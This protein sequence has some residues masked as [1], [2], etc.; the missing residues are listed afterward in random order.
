[1]PP[2][3]PKEPPPKDDFA[4]ASSDEED[5]APL[6]LPDLPKF[7]HDRRRDEVEVEEW[8][9]L[10]R[11]SILMRKMSVNSR[12]AM[13]FA[14]LSLR[15]AAATWFMNAEESIRPQ[16]FVAFADALEKWVRPV[17]LQ[18]VS[19]DQLKRITHSKSLEQYIEVFRRKALQV[20]NM[21]ELEKTEIFLDNLKP[22]LAEQ[23]RLQ[24]MDK[25]KDDLELVMSIALVVEYE[26]RKARRARDNFD[27]RTSAVAKSARSGFSGSNS[28]S[29][30]FKPK[31]KT[32]YKCGSPDHLLAQCPL[33]KK[34]GSKA[35]A[36]SAKAENA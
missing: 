8:I 36:N 15:G 26:K 35:K 21:S 32:C 33:K 7:F 27:N 13:R 1:M 31:P 10:A 18:Y 2:K 5:R 25:P 11:Q 30:D 24:R 12:E 4:S 29:K 20:K 34:G 9:M 17:P 14:A 23:V 22:S 6:K 16:S 28:K 19:R 3:E